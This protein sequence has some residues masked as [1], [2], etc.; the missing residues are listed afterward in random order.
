MELQY[1]RK[2]K[3]TIAI[4]LAAGNEQGDNYLFQLVKIVS[5]VLIWKV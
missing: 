3:Q 1:Y 2:N 4:L 5:H